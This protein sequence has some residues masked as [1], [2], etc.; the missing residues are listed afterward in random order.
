M[1]RLFLYLRNILNILN[2]LAKP[3]VVALPLL[4]SLFLSLFVKHQHVK[5]ALNIKFNPK[6][7]FRGGRAVPHCVFTETSTILSQAPPAVWS[8]SKPPPL[9]ANYSPLKLRIQF[10]FVELVNL[11]MNRGNLF[12]CSCVGMSESGHS[13]HVFRDTH[14]RLGCGWGGGRLLHRRS[15]SLI[16][17]N[18]TAISLAVCRVPSAVVD[19]VNLFVRGKYS[20]VSFI[21]T[22]PNMKHTGDIYWHISHQL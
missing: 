17:T 13:L 19:D 12:S 6:H 16:C 3:L 4:L 18:R 5:I 22:N 1:K 2:S 9:F 15:V 20:H 14:S 7:I 21:T 10:A 11:N 8:T